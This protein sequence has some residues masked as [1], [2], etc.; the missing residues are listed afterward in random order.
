MVIIGAKGMAKEVLS[1]LSLNGMGENVSFFDNIDASAPDRLFGTF[2]VLKSWE[3]LRRHFLRDPDVALGVGGALTRFKLACR[4]EELGGVLRTIVSKQAVIGYHGIEIS[5]GAYIA[6]Q[7]VIMTDAFIGEGALINVG[8]YLAHDT[9]IGKYSE[10][11]PGAKI[12]GR[13]SVGNLCEI[14]TNA[15]ILPDRKIGCNCVIGAGAVV[16]KDVPDNCVVVGI[17]ARIMSERAPI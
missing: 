14:G 9:K 2:P 5:K 4:A 3:D 11:S 12:L 6:P 1:V 7:A 8:V 15:V 13:A 10:I 16:T 17:P